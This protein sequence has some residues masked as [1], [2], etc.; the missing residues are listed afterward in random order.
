MQLARR[1][2]RGDRGA[3]DGNRT[4]VFSL[5]SRFEVS[6]AAS[7]FPPSL[8]DLRINVHARRG[9]CATVATSC[10]SVV[11][12][13]ASRR[14]AIPS[15]QRGTQG[16]AGDHP[17]L[18]KLPPHGLEDQPSSLSSSSAATGSAQAFFHNSVAR[19]CYMTARPNPSRTTRGS[20][21]NP[22]CIRP[23][24]PSSPGSWIDPAQARDIDGCD[25]PLTNTHI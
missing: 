13:A 24:G 19:T 15:R 16:P 8:G 23:S 21:Q 10:D 9:L 20:G 5:G 12:P 14:A 18:S 17:T 22:T 7:G 3:D 25:I 6:R 11:T 2:Y 1:I 4:R